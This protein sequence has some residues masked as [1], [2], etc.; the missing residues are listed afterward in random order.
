[1]TTTHA[2]PATKWQLKA[3]SEGK[4]EAIALPVTESD[5]PTSG[6]SNC[7]LRHGN[8]FHFDYDPPEWPHDYDEPPNGY[9]LEVP[10]QVGDRIFL[11]EEWFSV[12]N[13]E[14]QAIYP[15]NPS[16]QKSD[17]FF[18]KSHH[19][20]CGTQLYPAET[21]PA[22][23]AQ[24]WFEITDV[25]VLQAKDLTTTDLIKAAIAPLPLPP[26]SKIT[27]RWDATYP[28]HRWYGDRCL[29]KSLNRRSRWVRRTFS[30]TLVLTYRQKVSRS[31]TNGAI[32]SQVNCTAQLEQE[33]ERNTPIGCNAYGG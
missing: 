31:F 8:W 27:E 29:E 4:L 24:Y 5:L 32:S 14:S 15:E 23:A 30:I 11:Q 13:L 20:A 7:R 1:M 33:I 12:P 9:L 25:R 21:M 2:H 16:M 10:Y 28:E 17:Y 6:L 22:E 18:T 19:L 3:A 26:F